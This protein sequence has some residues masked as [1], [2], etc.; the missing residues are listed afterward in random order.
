MKK[1]LA[2][3]AA[4]LFTA[5]FTGC[6]N[7]EAGSIDSDRKMSSLSI[8][9]NEIPNDYEKMFLASY[10]KNE[11]N[12]RSITPNDP[13]EI[14]DTG[15]TF[16]LTGKSETGLTY[17][18]KTV[19]L[20]EDTENTGHYNFN[21][22]LTLESMLWTLTLTSYNDSPAPEVDHEGT[23][24]V[25]IGYST[26]D[27]RNGNGTAPFTMTTKGLTT[28]GSVEITGKVKD[29][30]SIVSKYTMGIYSKDK[31]EAVYGPEEV[32]A[33]TG[34]EHNFSYT[35]SDK[36]VNP[37]NYLF[38]M[39]F[40][41][42]EDTIIGSYVDTLIVNP[43]NA[44]LRDLGTLDII[45][46]IPSAPE[47]VKAY[48]IKDSETIEGYKVL[49]SWKGGKYATNF[50]LKLTEYAGDGTNDS[51]PNNIIKI[52]GLAGMDNAAT[53][54]VEDFITSDV[55]GTGTGASSMLYGDKTA[56][57]NLELG[58][59][60]E[61]QMRARNYIGTSKDATGTDDW[62][63]RTDA[64]ETTL[65]IGTDT[66]NVTGF[67][68]KLNRMLL[69]YNLNGG[70][71]SLD[72]SDE[73]TGKYAEYKTWKGTDNSLL[74]I[75]APVTLT[76][77]TTDF[78]KWLFESG[79]GLAADGTT[80]V[81]TRD[82]EVSKFWYKNLTVKAFYGNSLTG[83]VSME[84]APLDVELSDINVSY[85]TEASQA[86]E[87]TPAAGVYSISKKQSDGTDTYVC[88]TL[89]SA[90]TEYKNIRFEL[91]TQ[92][93]ADPESLVVTDTNKCV[94]SLGKY[95]P[96]KISV[97]VIADTN[98]KD[99]SQTITLDIY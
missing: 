72:G 25:L 41:N 48:L 12:S 3:T 37:G 11:S 33:T 29:S 32:N 65:T 88:V 54:T 46:K 39:V 64:T 81:T 18:P 96:G 90:T 76:K 35:N 61:I 44:L 14:A 93:N 89:S 59:I 74:E 36:K 69:T 34:T 8:S 26:V 82:E 70:K 67:E 5:M 92:S 80:E 56:I 22:T 19:T 60:Y 13:Y 50:E 58:K 51:D 10:P 16:V 45:G 71:L 23:S 42:T 77:G 68:S 53:K 79:T 73:Y 86:T 9:V 95:V 78:N 17:G 40:Y 7:S 4:L 62:T 2:G 30:D 91:T 6:M 27:L 57:L 97:R 47:N 85:G 99:R 21:E 87:A 83:D 31:G 98:V 63:N 43:G 38:K 66:V 49:V 84:D 28:T 94:F 24:P 1:I 20:A 75:T 15:L 55:Y 52:Y